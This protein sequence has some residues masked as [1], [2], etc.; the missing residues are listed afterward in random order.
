MQ[1]LESMKEEGNSWAK[2]DWEWGRER[3]SW[4]TRKQDKQRAMQLLES[5]KEQGRS[6]AMVAG[7]CSVEEQGLVRGSVLIEKQK[8]DK[9]RAMQLLESTTEQGR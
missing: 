7:R 3:F 8:Q 4:G 9:C 5:M 2:G 1:L 6:L